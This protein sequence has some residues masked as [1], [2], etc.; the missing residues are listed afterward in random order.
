MRAETLG[1]APPPLP[2]PL[3]E[4]S[5]VVSSRASLTELRIE[6]LSGRQRRGPAL[7]RG[8]LLEAL[9][10]NGGAFDFGESEVAAEAEGD[11]GVSTEE[12]VLEAVRRMPDPT[13]VRAA[14]GN[15]DRPLALALNPDFNRELTP[16]DAY[17]LSRVDG[18]LSAA[19]VLKLVPR[20]RRRRSGACSACS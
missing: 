11:P 8:P 18:K 1:Q 17:I 19:E 9:A 12:L 3:R 13:A 20:R 4:M 15:V 7:R 5:S 16:T 10:G 14:L 2:H 6:R